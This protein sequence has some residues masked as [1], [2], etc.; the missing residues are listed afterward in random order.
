MVAALQSRT[1]V[2]TSWVG[3]I[4]VRLASTRN[5]ARADSN[6]SATA[7]TPNRRA[8]RPGAAVAAAASSALAAWPTLVITRDH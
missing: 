2:T 4:G 6:A 1:L 7:I 3:G 5:V 8:A